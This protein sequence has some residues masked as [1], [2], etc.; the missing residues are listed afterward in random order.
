MTSVPKG[1][2]GA[3]KG[4]FAYNSIIERWPKI[5]TKVIDQMHQ[6]HSEAVKKFGMVS[7]LKNVNLLFV[8][9]EGD[10]DV[11]HIIHNLSRMRYLITTDKPLEPF[12]SELPNTD[13][14][15]ND[16]RHFQEQVSFKIFR[17]FC[18]WLLLLM[19]NLS[20]LWKK[21]LL[22]IFDPLPGYAI[23]NEVILCVINAQQ[24][25]T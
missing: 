19:I 10:A 24:K 8:L 5:I 18:V 14:W 22:S 25:C 11:K 23:L 21:R 9:W 16:L 7:F 4:S 3:V 13:K 6:H 15:N 1:C 2:C 17:I 20:E 12:V